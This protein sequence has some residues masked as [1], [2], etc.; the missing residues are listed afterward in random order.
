MTFWLEAPAST[1]DCF[2][3]IASLIDLLGTSL[4]LNTLLRAISDACGCFVDVALIG[5]S[6]HRLGRLDGHQGLIRLFSM[7]LIVDVEVCLRP[8]NTRRIIG[9]VLGLYE[10]VCGGQRRLLLFVR[11]WR[12]LSWQRL[13]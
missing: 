12:I 6:A 2:V 8:L 9:G 11:R 10:L 1:D 13:L 7:G 5:M 3:A 4:P